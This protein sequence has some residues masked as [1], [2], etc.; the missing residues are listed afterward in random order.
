SPGS[1][2]R[3]PARSPT[4]TF[5]SLNPGPDEGP[6]RFQPL[7]CGKE[8]RMVTASQTSFRFELLRD[9]QVAERGALP[10]LVKDILPIG[11]LAFLYGPPAVGKTFLALDWAFSVA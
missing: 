9:F 4:K 1:R 10:W 8:K 7:E 6:F 2:S 5:A 11:G 3:F